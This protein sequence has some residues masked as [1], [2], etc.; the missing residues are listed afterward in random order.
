[1]SFQPQ[2]ERVRI[3]SSCTSVKLLFPPQSE[4]RFLLNQGSYFEMLLKMKNN[5]MHLPT[6]FNQTEGRSFV[7]KLNNDN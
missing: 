6:V 5:A 4:K 1:M 2:I 7:L 3:G